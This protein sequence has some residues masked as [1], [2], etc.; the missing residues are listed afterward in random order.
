MKI[1][2]DGSVFVNQLTGIGNYSYHLLNELAM[3][4]PEHE[5]VVFSNR[6][7][8]VSFNS[9]NIHVRVSQSRIWKSNYLWKLQGLAAEASREE[10][11]LYW[12]TS[13]VGPVFMRIPVVLTVYDFVYRVEPSTMSWP[14]RLFRSFSQ[15][16]WIRRAHRVFAISSAVAGEMLNYFGRSADAVILPAADARFVPSSVEDVAAVRKKYGLGER[17][18]LLVGTLEP[19]KNVQMFVEAYGEF[20][21]KFSGGALPPLAIIGGKGWGDWKILASLRAVERAGLLCQ[22]GYVPT[23]DLPALYSGATLFFMPSRYEGFG[24]PILE[25]RK[26]GCPVVCSDVPAMREAGGPS[27]LY[28]PS[29]RDGIG[30]AMEEL[31]VHGRV[32][33]TDFGAGADWS[34]RSGAEQLRTILLDCHAG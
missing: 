25:A 8:N 5:F 30:W 20:S 24:M 26:C 14:S 31:Y 28:H 34:W 12:A 7:V 13:G 1:G 15:P 23:E 10:V 18:S 22:L 21:Q 9:A 33:V 6:P 2:I 17:Y 19:R 16:R 4:M 27:S 29:T 11:D 32:P 3:I